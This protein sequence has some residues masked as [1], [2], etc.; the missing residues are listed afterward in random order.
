MTN[1]QK[2]FPQTTVVI[3]KSLLLLMPIIQSTLT[4]AQLVEMGLS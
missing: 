3:L 2:Y 1:L 4:G